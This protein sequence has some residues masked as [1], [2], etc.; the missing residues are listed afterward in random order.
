MRF[1]AKIALLLAVTVL[2]ACKK[3]KTELV[4][5]SAYMENVATD[6]GNGSK[7]YLTNDEMWVC[8]E[9]SDQVDICPEHRVHTWHDGVDTIRFPVTNGFGSTLALLSRNIDKDEYTEI[10]H[11]PIYLFSPAN[12]LNPVPNNA[13]RTSWKITLPRVQPYRNDA[14]S[15]H[16]FSSKVLPMVA[17]S[18]GVNEP[19]QYFHPVCGILRLQFYSTWS[20]EIIIDSVKIEG[21]SKL[22]GEFVLPVA[23]SLG[24]PSI[25]DPEPYIKPVPV[26]AGTRRLDS[27]LV[28]TGINKS[29]G[30]GHNDLYTFYVPLPATEDVTQSSSD[31]SIFYTHYKLRVTVHGHKTDLTPMK[32]SK[33]ISD[34][35]IHRCNVTKMRALNLESFVN[36]PGAGYGTSSVQLVG[37]GTQERPFQ[38]YTYDDLVKVRTAF[39]DAKKGTPIVNGQPVKGMSDPGGPTYFKI[40]RSGITIPNDGVWQTGRGIKNFKGYMYVESST[41]NNGTIT[42]NSGYSLF[43]SIADD[44]KVENLYL[45]GT[46]NTAVHDDDFSPFCHENNGLIVNCHNLCDVTIDDVNSS[47]YDR[48]LAGLCAIN[49]GRIVGG[50]N[51][52]DLR[53]VTSNVAGIC[54]TNYGI[55]EGSFTMSHAIPQGLNIAGVCFENASG[56][57]VKDCIV[58]SSVNP[59][60]SS[61]NVGVIVFE[62]HGTISDCRS[63]GS[64]QYSVE[65]SIGG[66]CNTNYG[67]VND[68]SNTVEIVGCSNSVGGIVAVNMAGEIYNCDN[69]GDH[70]IVGMHGSNRATNA[71]GI[72][73]WLQGGK[74]VNCYNTCEVI[75]ATNSG[76]IVGKIEMASWV[77]NPADRPVQNCWTAYDLHLLGYNADTICKMGYSCFS[78][79]LSDF[80]TLRGCNRFSSATYQITG[81]LESYSTYTGGDITN[82]SRLVDALNYW[83]VT[84][85]NSKYWRWKVNDDELMPRFDLSPSA[86]KGYLQRRRRV[87]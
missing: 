26:A 73:G 87:N 35:A 71:G 68:C 37:N 12:L 17:Y 8:W 82:G 24:T 56:G 14:R 3:E 58:S 31:P 25:Q 9:S 57:Q 62:N 27:T 63:S 59:V 50:A 76:G 48:H 21:K 66:I 43:E 79:H 42:N 77:A 81:V 60:T 10:F 65:G 86:K 70:Q 1:K 53:S 38:I 16:S 15:D 6:D 20:T 30:G 34:V 40:C 52:G 45:D 13:A 39:E 54:Y 11:N 41:A 28:I 29:I 4:S 47:A 64:L 18:Q 84:N 78:S 22:S 2:A 72:V 85:G 36:D 44:G 19:Y 46:L 33:I 75:A 32:C 74:I 69:E 5:M 83:V 23:N 49:R 61:G 67:T 51:S 55:I 80:D 7:T